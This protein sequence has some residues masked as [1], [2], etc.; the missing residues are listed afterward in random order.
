MQNRFAVCR[1]LHQSSCLSAE[2]VAAS[3][4]ETRATEAFLAFTVSQAGATIAPTEATHVSIQVSIDGTWSAAHVAPSTRSQ[5]D[6]CQHQ[7]QSQTHWRELHDSFR[8][9]GVELWLVM[10]D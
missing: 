9:A 10:R 7:Q 1:S 8:A 6:E 2:A 5:D 3:S 4:A